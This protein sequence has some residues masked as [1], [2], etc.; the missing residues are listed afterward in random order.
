MG[1]DIKPAIW[2]WIEGKCCTRSGGSPCFAEAFQNL[3]PRIPATWLHPRDHF[4][5]TN[6]R[7]WGVP[8]IGY[9]NRWMFIGVDR[10]GKPMV[11]PTWPQIGC[12]STQDSFGKAFLGCVQCIAQHDITWTFQVPNNIGT[13]CLKSSFEAQFF[14]GLGWSRYVRSLGAN[15]WDTRAAS[16]S[17]CAWQQKAT[18]CWVCFRQWVCITND[19]WSFPKILAQL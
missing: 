1:W 16:A 15:V 2:S 13:A 8:E 3:M 12:K 5:S 18:T 4:L 9:P 17:N 10:G 7:K 11:F 14:L 6:W 19:P